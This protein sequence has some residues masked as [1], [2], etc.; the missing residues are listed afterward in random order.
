M[1][2]SLILK[3]AIITAA[4]AVALPATAQRAELT[5]AFPGAEGW[6]RYTTGG[7]GGAVVR[8]SN[9][10]DS[11]PGS[12]RNAVSRSGARIVIFDVSGTIHLKS[13]LKITNPDITIAG[14]T[15]PGD[16]ICVADYPVSINT[17]NVIIRYM[18]FRP[19]NES[20]TNLDGLDALTGVD[21]HHIIIDHCSMSW[22]TDECCTIYGNRFST[23]QWCLIS[24]SLRWGGHSKGTHGY[25]GMMGGE[26]A[27]YH[28][29]LLAH[30]DSRCPRMGERPKTGPRDTTDF[31]CNVMYN[32]SGLGCYGGENMNM[33]FVNN[34]Y[35][36]GPATMSRNESVQKRICGIG[37]N[38]DQS[39]PM[40]LTWA[41]VYVDGNVNTLH[42]DVAA[43]NWTNGIW[44][45]I[46]AKYRLNS[47]W[48]LDE[49]KMHLAEP[50]KYYYV[51]THT[52]ADA[53]E[54]VLDYAGASLSR[55]ELDR[56]I[57][58]DT[59]DGK[60]TY[61][62]KGDGNGPG[63]IDSPRDNRPADAG[64]DWSPWPALA[65]T[66]APVDTDRDGMPDEWETAR[67]LNPSDPSDALLTDDEGYTMIECYINSLVEDITAAQNAGGTAD[68][69]IELRPEIAEM[70]EVSM[71]TKTDGGWDFGHGITLS[72][73]NY[74]S[75]GNY[76]GMSSGHRH[77]L[78]LPAFAK[79]YGVGVE[80]IGR[81][82]SDR[83]GD[84]SLVELAGESYPEGRYTLPKSGGAGGFTVA[85]SEP[86]AD[87]LTMT[88][89]GNHAMCVI[90]LYTTPDPSLG[91][92]DAVIS[93]DGHVTD[94]RWF[95]LQ[96]IEVAAPTAPGLYIHDGRKVWV[97]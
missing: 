58:G 96:G 25:G 95:N 13:E 4:A 48:N 74:S 59:R 32:W 10:N 44:K 73:G 79:V 54:R 9:L 91:V 63:I 69:S 72:G 70:Y 38:E 83:Y 89:A 45:H 84:A 30:H 18:R 16:G 40:Y 49:D 65:S 19:G 51:T 41:T 81:Y 77:T 3:S 2:L 82:S 94:D 88:W 7:R 15:A 5:P 68:G 97:K 8:V 67:G 36:P 66:V 31:R 43:D 11:G 64:S 29:N 37:V 76:V 17:G 92:G 85:L 12:L 26:G 47:K 52:A 20:S 80:G 71:A 56:T 90:T 50:M 53:Y 55:D 24:Q 46:D 6:G 42:E 61:T 28:H 60:A 14:Q 33:N 93:P 35:K 22:S 78:T 86:V 39:N 27:S 62:G 23:V 75:K 57:V 21:S 87:N 1:K 34:T